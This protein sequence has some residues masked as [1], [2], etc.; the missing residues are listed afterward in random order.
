MATSQ[1]YDQ[2]TDKPPDD[3]S[4]LQWAT[5][6]VDDGRERRRA[7]EGLWWENIATFCG[8]LWVEWDVH[9]RKLREPVEKPDYRVRLPVNLAQPVVRTELAKLT[10]NKPI[11][12]VMARSNDKTDLNA[13]QM[14]G[15]LLN[16]YVER[17]FHMPKVRRRM[18]HWVLMCGS[19][20]IFVDYDE[21]AQEKIQVMQDPSGNPVFDMRV[22]EAYRAYYKKQKKSPKMMS[23]PMGEL[24]IKPLSPFQV[25]WDFSQLYIEDAWWCM[26]SDAMDVVEVERRWGTEVESDEEAQPGV[27]ERRLLNQF[28]LSMK[29]DIQPLNA[30][31]LAL[32]HRLFVKPGHPFFPN[33][34]HL[35]F[36]KDKIVHKEAFPHAHGELPV[37]WMG[38]IP[39]PLSQHA[40]SVLQ[41]VKP[42]VMELSRTASQLVENRNLMANPPWRVAKQSKI[43]SGEIQNKPGLRLKYVAMPNI[44]P[45]EPVQ[46]PEIPTYVKDLVPMIREHILEISGQGE[47]SQG[48]VPPG[49]RS[50]V[51]IAY[52]QEEDDT[53]LGPSVQEFEETIERVSSQTLEVIAERYDVPR[54]VQI[55]RKHSEPEV[56]D[57]MGSMLQGNTAVICQAGSALP[58]SK[59]AKQQYILDLYD[60]KLES[61]PR[62]VREM[63]ELSEGEPEEFEIDMQQAERE[64]RQLQQGNNPGVEPWYNHAAHHFIH[65]RFMKSPDFESLDEGAKAAF[66]EHD[67]EHTRAEQDQMQ[68]QAAQQA[69][70]GGPPSPNGG[71]PQG[72]SAPP[73]EGA[74]QPSA[75]G[76]QRP[77]G[78]PPPYAASG[79]TPRSLLDQQPQ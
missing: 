10:K 11:T 1:S 54:T 33:G 69:A 56:F 74:G 23:I 21:T 40:M 17:N 41:Q 61:D 38:H 30:Q 35:V 12:D 66:L 70:M 13:A 20:G 76:Q 28:D 57:F 7:Q 53:R 37:S 68:Q 42:L 51:A 18:L 60:R 71:G 48:R 22:I 31:K 67:M 45:P 4:L 3:E 72:P 47:T 39:M 29:L 64:N 79:P 49:A 9:K 25:V 34:L 50:G 32:V 15:K 55:Y 43:E 63:L 62:R 16:N 27:I 52:L 77:E 19:G 75:N 5:T 36:T 8:D 26:V 2:A 44:P 78:P 14:S 24:V 73:Q 65:R 46:M 59:A 58:R 6:L